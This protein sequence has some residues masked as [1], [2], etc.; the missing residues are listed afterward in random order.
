MKTLF[1]LFAIL[2]SIPPANAASVCHKPSF[3]IDAIKKLHPSVVWHKLNHRQQ[4]LILDNVKV[5]EGANI[6]GLLTAADVDRAV[7]IVAHNGCVIGR[8]VVSKEARDQ[9]LQLGNPA[10]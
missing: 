3:F 4:K 10:A 2:L 8:V 5:P 1:L 9:I 6:A 7:I